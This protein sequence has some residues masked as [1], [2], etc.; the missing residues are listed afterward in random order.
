MNNKL[1]SPLITKNIIRIFPSIKIKNR[2]KNFF[3]KNIIKTEI[4][5]N[6]IKL[7]KMTKDKATNL[8]NYITDDINNIDQLSFVKDKFIV[9]RSTKEQ[10][11]EK[12]NTVNYELLPKIRD[13]KPLKIKKEF[14]KDFENKILDVNNIN[15]SKNNEDTTDIKEEKNNNKNNKLSKVILKIVNKQSQTEKNINNKYTEINGILENM[16]KI[17]NEILTKK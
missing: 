2:N 1:L 13:Q 15:N 9:F 7:S 8:N 6:K 4:N 11:K 3:K 14:F 16:Q 10:K 12:F 5:T 17:T